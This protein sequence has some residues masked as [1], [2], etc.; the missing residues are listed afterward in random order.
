MGMA[1]LS[2]AQGLHSFFLF[3]RSIFILKIFRPHRKAAGVIRH[4]LRVLG[5]TDPFV[6]CY[7]SLISIQKHSSLLP[8]HLKIAKV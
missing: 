1:A 4:R 8:N 3:Y 5:Q 6:S 2:T 7:M